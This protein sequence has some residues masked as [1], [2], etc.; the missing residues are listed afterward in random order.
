M[1]RVVPS[2]CFLLRAYREELD[3][4]AIFAKSNM[5]HADY[6]HGHDIAIPLPMKVDLKHLQS[7]PPLERKYFAT[8]KVCEAR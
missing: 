6:R 7:I 1:D 3:G 8:F 2:S 4:V 5:Q